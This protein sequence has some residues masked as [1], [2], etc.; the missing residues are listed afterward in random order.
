MQTIDYQH[1]D[2]ENNEARWEFYLRSY[3]GG[4]EYQD[5][6]YLTGYLNESENEYARRIQLTPLD[7]HCRN[8]VHIYSSFLWRTPPV[9]VY[10]SLA[11]NAALE[12]FTDDADLDG[13]NINSFM[14]QA[15]IWASVYGNVWIMVDKPQ[16]NARTRA[17]ELDQDIRPYVSLFTPENVFDWKWERTPS[18]RFELT[19]LKLREAVDR[20][21]AT[22]KVSYYRVWR[23]DTIEYWKSDGEDEVLMETIDNSLGVIPA[24]YLPA[25]RSVTRSIGISDLSD[26]AYMQKAIYSELSEIEQLIRISNHPS[27]VKT[28]DT[29]ASAGAG[30]VIN[31]SD[32]MDGKVQPYL[33]QPSGQNIGS[34]R[35]S[36]KDKIEAINRMAHMGA[37]RG[38]EVITQS[39]VAMQT[40]FQMLNAKLSEKADL[41]ELAEEQMWTYFCNWLDIPPDVEVFYPDSFD[42]RDYDKELLFLQQMKASGVRSATLAQEIDKQIADLVLDDE[43]LAK[44]HIEI[45]QGTSTLGQFGV[46]AETAVFALQGAEIE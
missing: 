35:E 31:V 33:L 10:N 34:I 1:P 46:G 14:K 43:N 45:E 41:L 7:N 18:G 23:K 37:V 29:D 11:N 25:A 30:S 13:M 12:Q 44:S 19:Y 2:Y 4:Q 39:G 32:D 42:L 20:E 27:L 24:V 17:E 26:I 3:I 40:E 9:R 15:Q 5:G 38:T 36:I 8:V 22:T 21:T 6:N 28:Y 16:S